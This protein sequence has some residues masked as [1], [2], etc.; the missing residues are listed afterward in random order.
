MYD[1]NYAIYL[2]YLPFTSVDENDPWK[3]IAFLIIQI[4]NN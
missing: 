2:T 1:E 3:I 4:G